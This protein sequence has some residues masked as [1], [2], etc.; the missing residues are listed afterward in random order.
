[1][2]KILQQFLSAY[3]KDEAEYIKKWMVTW[4][5][6]VRRK[7]ASKEY[8][9]Q[10]TSDFF[11]YR[12]KEDLVKWMNW[13]G[14]EPY[15][16]YIASDKI[17][18]LVSKSRAKDSL[19]LNKLGLNF[20]FSVYDTTV[21]INNAQDFL[22]PQ[23]YPVPERNSIKTIVDCGAGYGRQANLWASPDKTYIGIDAIPNSYC[24][25]N[26]YYH[27]VSDNVT[28]YVE[29]AEPKPVNIEQKGI[30]HLP[31]WRMD[32]I[33]DESCDL[34]ICIQVLAELNSTLIK[35]LV[36]QFGRILKPGGMFYIRD[37]GTAVKMATSLDYDKYITEHDFSLEFKPHVIDK[38]DIHGIPRIYRK[39]DAK[40]LK[41]QAKSKEQIMREYI[42]EA[43]YLTGGVLSKI[44][45]KVSAK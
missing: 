4:N 43:D 2:E 34:V 26:L 8:E 35:Y 39:N 13:F 29:S 7:K 25:Q 20:D 36:T 23:L 33:P 18:E 28:D 45:R 42:V 40:V 27:N 12:G 31:T 44:K 30:H 3:K 37:H 38:L 32:L 22:I 21:G 16:N 14:K 10:I 6:Q 11:D 15:G 1:M 41:A 24:L 17:Q 9:A 19:I 5:Y